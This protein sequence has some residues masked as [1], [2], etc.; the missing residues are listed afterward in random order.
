M[1]IQTFRKQNKERKKKVSAEKEFCLLPR[2][3]FVRTHI[4]THRKKEEKRNKRRKEK[5]NLV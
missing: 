1:E 4:L 2:E 3:I 5:R